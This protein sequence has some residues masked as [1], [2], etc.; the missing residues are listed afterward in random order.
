V[1]KGTGARLSDD[2][3]VQT[4]TEFFRY[5]GWADARVFK[6]CLR[7]ELPLLE[8][9]AGGTVG[10]IDKSLRHMVSVEEGFAALI[11][12]TAGA[13]P[14]GLSTQEAFTFHVGPTG[15]ADGYFKHD[16]PWYAERAAQ[17]D[18]HFLRLATTATLEPEEREVFVPWLGFAMTAQQAM[19]QVLVHNGHHR[20]QVF[21][22]LGDRGVKVPD[23]DHVVMLAKERQ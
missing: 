22:A 21:S 18:D 2:L 13:T 19:M 8:E 5:N 15:L 11:A 16:L 14:P 20:S 1:I 6:V 12:G 4:L 23:L 17:L 10:T 7:A 9:D 3:R